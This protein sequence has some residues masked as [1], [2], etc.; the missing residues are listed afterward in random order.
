[1]PYRIVEIE[2]LKWDTS[3]SLFLKI[4]QNKGLI[5][6]HDFKLFYNYD[7][8]TLKLV[9]SRISVRQLTLN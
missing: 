6:I 8:T 2:R 4:S 9:H 7:G 1:M 5:W 3:N